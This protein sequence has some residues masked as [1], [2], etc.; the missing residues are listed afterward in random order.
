MTGK[1]SL[2]LLWAAV[3]RLPEGVEALRAHV[4]RMNERDNTNADV[5]GTDDYAST[6]R[7]TDEQLAELA[8]TF[9]ASAGLPPPSRLGRGPKGGRP[10]RPSP[11]SPNVSH[12]STLAERDYAAF[13]FVKLEFSSAAIDKFIARQTKGVGLST[14]RA[15]SAVVEPLERMMRARGW[16]LREKDRLKQWIPPAAKEPSDA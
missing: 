2:R 10:R 14:H 6:K 5:K 15:C 9:R 12:L 4:V 1:A 11:G 3:R 8:E 16:T 13:L 7:L